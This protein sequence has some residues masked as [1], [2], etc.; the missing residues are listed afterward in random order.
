[1]LVLLVR[2]FEEMLRQLRERVGGEIGRDGDVLE[3]GAKFI[4]N[5][6]VNRGDYL[7][8]CQHGFSSGW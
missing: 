5:L 4:S 7:V 2:L 6:L 1:M 8:I 3:R